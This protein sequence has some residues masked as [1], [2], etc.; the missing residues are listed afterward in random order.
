MIAIR[1]VVL[2]NIHTTVTTIIVTFKFVSYSTHH[3]SSWYYIHQGIE[4]NLDTKMN[5]YQNYYFPVLN[6]SFFYCLSKAVI[7]H[8][9]KVCFH[10]NQ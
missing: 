1:A 9:M 3:L 4:K 8:H 6:R 5:T 10:M 7:T 2:I